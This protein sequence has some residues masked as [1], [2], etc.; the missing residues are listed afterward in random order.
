MVNLFKF[1]HKVLFFAGVLTGSLGMAL[2]SQKSFARSYTAAQIPFETCDK[3]RTD[4][5]DRVVQ[6]HYGVYPVVDSSQ[7][8]ACIDCLFQQAVNAD[9]DLNAFRQ[10]QK[11]FSEEV[12]ESKIPFICFFSSAVRASSKRG[13][14]GSKHYYY[15]DSALSNRI[16]L[17][18]GEFN[19]SKGRNNKY[20]ARR[21][22]LSEDYTRI[23]YNAFHYMSHCM[24][25]EKL[26]DRKQLFALYNHESSF[27][28]NN[29]SETGARCYGQLTSGTMSF[30]DRH[31]RYNT[32]KYSRIL[33]EA[34][35][36]CPDLNKKVLAPRFQNIRSNNV[37]GKTCRTTQHPNTCFFYSMLFIKDNSMQLE[38]KM[39]A[40]DRSFPI[41]AD[42]QL[43][44]RL[45]KDFLLP[46]RHKEVLVVKGLVTRKGVQR[47]VDWIFKNDYE[48]YT[49]FKK[50]GYTRT[51]LLVKKVRIY[52]DVDTRWLAIH[53]AYN[54]GQAIL[55][56]Y[57]PNFIEN[58]K[59]T[60][61]TSCTPSDK[62][63]GCLQRS[64]LL[65]NQPLSYDTLKKEWS[66]FIGWAYEAK[67]KRRREV[68]YFYKKIK[69]DSDYLKDNKGML[70]N[71]LAST[72]HRD[73]RRDLQFQRRIN[74]FV[75]KS[76]EQC[77]IF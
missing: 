54:G 22:C 48:L 4:F 10:T 2:W 74:R 30:M 63:E 39:N 9:E 25:F 40:P 23:T 64:S 38:A 46:I 70:R 45:K 5:T 71:H 42:P 32:P 17:M 75:E 57:F 77:S 3:M 31:L 24:G 66:A 1:P 43:A 76:K 36:R 37:G 53:T 11:Y 18:E 49:T 15:C 12:E 13:S 26:E 14:R 60:L 28:V 27:I 6:Q 67:R 41:N 72:L 65:D 69:A 59:L 52:K 20:Y 7:T 62:S 51:N 8:E 50:L 33:A 34:L 29:R 55:T 58:K 61:A 21:V 68:A 56:K 35:K 73:K 44:H 47:E 16:S 19:P